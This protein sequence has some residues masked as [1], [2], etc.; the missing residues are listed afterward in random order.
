M[1]AKRAM[2]RLWRN[3]ELGQALDREGW[4]TKPRTKGRMKCSYYGQIKERKREQTGGQ[5]L[6]TSRLGEER[7]EKGRASNDRVPK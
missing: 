6:Q 2:R 4:I 3:D 7:V 5:L 1:L